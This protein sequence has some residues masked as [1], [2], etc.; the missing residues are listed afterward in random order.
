MLTHKH[1]SEHTCM[2]TYVC[3]YFLDQK[4][5]KIAVGCGRNYKHTLSTKCEKY[6][7]LLNYRFCKDVIYIVMDHL[8]IKIN[9]PCERSVYLTAFVVIMI[10]MLFHF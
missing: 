8:N 3:I 10:I 9:Q 4:V 7:E 5:P 6:K 1:T 2:H